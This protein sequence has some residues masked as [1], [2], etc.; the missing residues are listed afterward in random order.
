MQKFYKF[1]LAVLCVFLSSMV[2][3]ILFAQTR[4]QTAMASTPIDTYIGGY[5][6]SLPANYNSTTQSYPLM[7]FL[8][9]EAEQGDG[10]AAQLPIVLR[11]GPPMQIDEQYNQNTNAN[12]P[13]PVV[14][15]GRSYE[16]I[17]ISPQMNTW[18]AQT[19]PEQQ[20]VGDIITYAM[21]HYRVDPTKVALTGLSMGGG[22]AIEYPGQDTT[23]GKRLNSLVGVA[24]ASFDSPERV[25]QIALAD[26]PVWLTDNNADPT[27]ATPNTEG[28]IS[29]L[30]A[31]NE[32]PP[33]VLTIFNA[34]GHG[35]WLPTYGAPGIPGITNSDGLNVY[36]WMAHFTRMGDTVVVDGA[37]QPLP[38]TWGPYKAIV[39]D[40]STVR[41]SWSTLE[42]ENNRY[43]IVQ[44]SIDGVQ[45]KGIDTVPAANQPHSYSYTDLA[46]V[47]GSDYYRLEQ[48]DL[49]GKYTYS[50][51]MEVNIA[52]A[53]ASMS[54]Q[55][56]PNPAPGLVTLTLNDDETGALEVSLTDVMGRVLHQWTF[57]KEVQVWN[58]TIDPG[59][60]AA[61]T[62]YIVM[63]G[64]KGRQVRSFIRPK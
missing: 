46:P 9:G 26:L 16:F 10:S 34:S 23:F 52:G 24:I 28:Y 27:G 48:V 44:R 2:P 15:N 62:Y 56:M 43:F 58:Q 57:G 7:I 40:S 64:P 53:A 51:V 13:D 54:L 39:T 29:Q 19:G 5:Y 3:G 30:Q 36:Q 20:M 4:T 11:N 22:I 31:L 37:T 50:G 42:E 18:P 49:D 35:G 32:V 59:N 45:Y 6:I 38:L 14:V 47:T 12:F 1:C 17:V 60:L 8:H 41:V 63:K 55:L 33:P 25:A 61:G 21:A